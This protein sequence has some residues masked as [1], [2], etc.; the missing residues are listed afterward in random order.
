MRCSAARLRRDAT[1]IA[2]TWLRP[3]SQPAGS[4]TAHLQPHRPPL[5]RPAP[6]APRPAL[7]HPRQRMRPSPIRNG[8]QQAVRQA[9]PQPQR[10]PLARRAVH[11]LR[12]VTLRAGRH[13]HPS[14]VRSAVQQAA[15]QAKRAAP[16]AHRHHNRRARQLPGELKKA[17]CAQIS[18]L[19]QRARAGLWPSRGALALTLE[20]GQGLRQPAAAPG[21]ERLRLVKR[22][23]W[24]GHPQGTQQQ[25]Q[26]L[27]QT[28]RTAL[29]WCGPGPCRR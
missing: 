1:R 19:A 3:R 10:R 21:P 22:T 11:M 25:L 2:S 5:A 6:R 12:R 15:T 7:L 17:R 18:A 29:S 14:T 13:M 24:Q 16:R 28:P 26:A 4:S 27:T 23:C 9:H 8:A 20:V